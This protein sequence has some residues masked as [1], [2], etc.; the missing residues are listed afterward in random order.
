MCINNITNWN[1]RIL[2]SEPTHF[3]FFEYGLWFFWRLVRFFLLVS[4]RAMQKDANRQRCLRMRFCWG[5]KIADILCRLHGYSVASA[6]PRQCD[7]W[8]CGCKIQIYTRQRNVIYGRM[9][10]D[11]RIFHNSKCEW[12]RTTRRDD[13]KKTQA[14]EIFVAIGW[15]CRNNGAPI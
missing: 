12:E 13:K 9:A 5:I 7:A 11:S 15:C 1:Q 10:P 6:L 3:F 2:T 14:A 4:I 8:M